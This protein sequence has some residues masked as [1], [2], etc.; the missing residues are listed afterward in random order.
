MLS[1]SVF[2]MYCCL[3]MYAEVASWQPGEPTGGVPTE[4]ET[5]PRV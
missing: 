4:E 1:K 2:H 5:A 3:L